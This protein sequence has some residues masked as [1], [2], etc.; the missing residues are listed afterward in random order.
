MP[1]YMK[2]EDIDGDVTTEGYAKWIEVHS[3][4]WGARR[5]IEMPINKSADR[6]ALLPAVSEITL[7][8]S[9][10]VSSATLF[11]EAVGGDMDRTVNIALCS[12]R[13]KEMVELARYTLYNT[14]VSGYSF[15]ANGETPVENISL[16]F[17]QIEIKYT[18]LNRDPKGNPA[19]TNFDLARV[20]LNG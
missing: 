6:E 17:T 11:E 2:Y 1:L 9:M 15:S 20:K 7:T 4:T 8:K 5:E 14:A 19:V 16:N 13:N 3:L 12:V 10:D 18:T